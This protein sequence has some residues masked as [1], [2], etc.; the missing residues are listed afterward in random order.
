MLHGDRRHTHRSLGHAPSSAEVGWAFTTD[1]PIEAQ[2]VASNDGA[3]LYAVTLGGTLFALDLE[4][5]LSFKVS[6]GARAYATPCVAPD[7]TLY[8]GI[9]GGALMALG[10]DGRVIW[11]LETDGDADTSPVRLEDGLVVFAA[12]RRLY[13]VGASGAIA[14]RFQAKGKIFT[15]P[16]IAM[17]A[18]DAPSPPLL[19]FGSQD[20]HV[21]AVSTKGE[22]IWSVDLGHDIDGAPAI[23]DDGAIYVGTDG[24]QVVRLTPDGHVTWS[25]DVGGYVRGPLSVARNGDVLAGVYGPLSRLVRI[26]PRG[27]VVG[28]YPAA[29]NGTRETGVFGGAVEDADGVLLF[30]AEDGA[31][32]AVGLSGNEVWRFPTAMD[33]DSPVTLTEGG[34]VIFGS[35]DGNVYALKTAAHTSDASPGTR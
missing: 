22:L 35:Y 9:D 23:A 27:E 17:A 7:G 5:H 6:L 26:S 19:V 31:V 24:N 15:A 13:G 3:T 8:V 11:R 16:A 32:H 30:G 29:I 12:G 34:Q 18:G 2:V 14:F 10:P 33:V 4:G 28:S 21:Y 20:H 1:G 25:R